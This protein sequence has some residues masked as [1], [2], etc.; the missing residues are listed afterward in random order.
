MLGLTVLDVVETNKSGT[1]SMSHLA[2]RQE[3]RDLLKSLRI[4]AIDE[5][6]AQVRTGQ[7]GDVLTDP[8]IAPIAK[9]S[10]LSS[11]A[12]TGDDAESSPPPV[13]SGETVAA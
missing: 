6:I 4:P 11:A 13:E 10:A 2:A 12:P 3:V 1:L 7:K 9:E 5:R 8:R